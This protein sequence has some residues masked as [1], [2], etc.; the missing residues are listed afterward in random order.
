MNRLSAAQFDPYRT[1]HPTMSLR[2]SIAG[3]E[4]INVASLPQNG[5]MAMDTALYE[6]SW[7]VRSSSNSKR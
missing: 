2:R 5:V 6:F 1:G 3:S 7:R 4:L